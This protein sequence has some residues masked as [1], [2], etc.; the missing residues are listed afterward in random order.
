MG[1]QG[2]DGTRRP[3]GLPAHSRREGVPRHPAPEGQAAIEL[4][5]FKKKLD[6]EI[7]GEQFAL[8][9]QAAQDINRYH[10]VS[11]IERVEGAGRGFAVAL[12]NDP[13]Y[14]TRGIKGDPID[15]A[16]R[17]HEGRTLPANKPL[18]WARHAAT[19][20]N[21]PSVRLQHS[22]ALTCR[23]YGPPLAGAAKAGS[24]SDTSRSK[25]GGEM[26]ADPPRRRQK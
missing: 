26:A 24:R 18:A 3:G 20:R 4:K 22:Y 13:S 1:D 16:F 12:T 9:N 19:G 15:A 8:P 6:V 14:W 25:Q 17:L 2:A 5:Y 11:D 10:F 23:D 21:K 7:G